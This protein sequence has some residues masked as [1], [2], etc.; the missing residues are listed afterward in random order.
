MIRWTIKWFGSSHLV[1]NKTFTNPS[2]KCSSSRSIDSQNMDQKP[3]PFIGPLINASIQ[4]LD[5]REC[6]LSDKYFLA[7]RVSVTCKRWQEAVSR[8]PKAFESVQSFADHS[9][10]VLRLERSLV[11][12][13]NGRSS[14]PFRRGFVSHTLV[15]VAIDQNPVRLLLVDSSIVI[16]HNRVRE[17]R[18]DAWRGEE[19]LYYW[20]EMGV[21]GHPQNNHTTL[22]Y[23]I[24]INYI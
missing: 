22:I 11:N 20:G 2:P 13:L 4:F 24:N 17:R 8:H 15:R 18:G 7:N 9:K 14:Q 1:S 19:I 10:D 21:D 16:L 12:S 5:R 3:S 6:A 23:I